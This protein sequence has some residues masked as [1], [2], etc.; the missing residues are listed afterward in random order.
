MKST[1][2]FIIR[3]GQT[4]WNVI[5]K[6]QGQI[7]IPLNDTGIKQAQ[8]VASFLKNKNLSPHAL[9]SSDLQRAHQT[10]QQISPLFSLNIITTQHLRERHV[11]ILQGLTKK[12]VHEMHGT[13]WENALDTEHGGESKTEFVQRLTNELSRISKNHLNESVIIV[14]HGHAIRQFIAYAGYDKNEWPPVT[15]ASIITV[16]YHHGDTSQIELVS[17]ESAE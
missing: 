14:T 7:D 16:K 9:Y 1:T 15:N 8:L 12:Q 2:L 3:H 11:G 6:I 17:I 10:A 4:D 13:H 5:E